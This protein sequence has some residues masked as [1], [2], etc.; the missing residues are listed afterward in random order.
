MREI[1]PRNL[2]AL[3]LLA[4]LTLREQEILSKLVRSQLNK[5]VAHEFGISPRTVEIHRAHIMDKLAAR[6]LSDVVRISLSA[7]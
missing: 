3:E 7:A 5:I 4:H 1:A 2:K 6:N